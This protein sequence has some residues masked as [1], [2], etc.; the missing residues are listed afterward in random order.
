[1]L[2]EMFRAFLQKK[3]PKIPTGLARDK[4]GKEHELV[5]Y[6]FNSCPYCQRVMPTLKALNIPIQF[7]DIHQDKQARQEL[8]DIGG[9]KQVPCLFIDGKPLYESLDIIQYLE[10]NY[11]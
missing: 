11:V 6:K 9:K 8:L 2:K 5:L 1:M 7:K 4:D 3:P 10:D